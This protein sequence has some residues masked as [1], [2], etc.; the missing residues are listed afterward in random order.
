MAV[1]FGI[2]FHLGR[3][4]VSEEPIRYAGEVQ[5]LTKKWE[6]DPDLFCEFDI[7]NFLQ[8]NGFREPVMMAYKAVHQTLPI[9]GN[10]LKGSNEFVKMIKI[11]CEQ[12]IVDI[13]VQ[14]KKI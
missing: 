10:L 5:C 14:E 9:A 6:E 3:I 13:Y 12:G 11:A 8:E 7:L 2:C 4:F 1:S